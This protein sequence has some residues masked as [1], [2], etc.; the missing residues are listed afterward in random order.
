MG[1]GGG[2]AGRGVLP[3]HGEKDRQTVGRTERAKGRRRA[4]ETRRGSKAA[5]RRG[6]DDQCLA[7]APACLCPGLHFSSSGLRLGV[8]P[9]HVVAWSLESK[10]EFSKG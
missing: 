8:S 4:G 1:R 9:W 5:S 6:R 2:W 10:L 3:A 7:V